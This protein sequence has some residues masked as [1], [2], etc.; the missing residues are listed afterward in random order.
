MGGHVG[1]QRTSAQRREIDQLLPMTRISASMNF[2]C[3]IDAKH[4]L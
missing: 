1:S 4:S 3:D 2:G